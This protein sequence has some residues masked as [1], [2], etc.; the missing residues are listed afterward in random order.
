MRLKSVARLDIV[1]DQDVE[2][3]LKNGTR[4][5]RGS[6]SRVIISDGLNVSIPKSFSNFFA[7]SKN[8]GL[9]IFLAI[10]IVNIEIPLGE[11]VV[12]VYTLKNGKI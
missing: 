12:L 8:E 4:D 11:E 1:F 3:N 10:N 2:N 7:N 5:R 6:A 9:F